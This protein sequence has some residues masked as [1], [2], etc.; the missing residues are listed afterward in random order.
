MMDI[1]FL[2]LN[3]NELDKNNEDI[4]STYYL[5]DVVKY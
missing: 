3:V 1:L 5:R 2:G 4:D